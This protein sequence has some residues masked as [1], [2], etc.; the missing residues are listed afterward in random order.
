MRLTFSRNLMLVWLALALSAGCAGAA[1]AGPLPTLLPTLTPRG[2]LP[3]TPSMAS[4]TPAP[5]EAVISLSHIPTT[6]PWPTRAP[7]SVLSAA[8]AYPTWPAEAQVVGVVGHRQRLSLSC[9]ARAT[10]D[11]AAFFGVTI[12]EL[13][14][15]RQLPKSD[16]PNLGFV[17]NVRGRWGQVPPASYGV[18]AE[19]VAALLR[20]TYHLNAVAVRDWPWSDLQREL[21]AGRPVIVWVTGHVEDGTAQ[22]YTTQAGARVRVAPFEHTVLVTGYTAE[23][24]T[25]VDGAKTYTRTLEQFWRSWAVLGNMAVI[26]REP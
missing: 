17:G 16:D 13:T 1:P 5:P 11:W 7:I 22:I 2:T 12:D 20:E 9:E 25:I 15:Q 24:V 18:H 23:R 8:T 4:P 14:F 21:M 6:T 3:N 19:P 26:L 10:A